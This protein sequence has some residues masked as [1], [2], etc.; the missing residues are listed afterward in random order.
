M[1]VKLTLKTKNGRTTTV[2]ILTDCNDLI[3][4]V[5]KEITERVI[6]TKTKIVKIEII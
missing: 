5:K 6:L 3:E 1:N 2:E 4:F